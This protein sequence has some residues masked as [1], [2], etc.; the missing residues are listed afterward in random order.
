M[1]HFWLMIELLLVVLQAPSVIN[2][3]HAPEAPELLVLSVA[4]GAKGGFFV[5]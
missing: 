3:F 2:E 1:S 5:E 4:M